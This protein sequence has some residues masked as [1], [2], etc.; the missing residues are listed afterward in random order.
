MGIV[1]N[2]AHGISHKQVAW[3]R[4]RAI[5]TIRAVWKMSVESQRNI[6]Y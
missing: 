6:R 2:E 5:T 3:L 1:V 4:E